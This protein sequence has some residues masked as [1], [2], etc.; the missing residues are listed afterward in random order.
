MKQRL[1]LF[2]LTPLLLS[3]TTLSNADTIG[4][5]AEI[6]KSIPEASL[7]ADPKSQAWAHSARTIL[8]VAEE[9][10]TETIASIQKITDKQNT[11]LFCLPNNE[12]IGLDIVHKTLEKNVENL[13]RNNESKTLSE[14]VITDLIAHYPCPADGFKSAQNELFSSKNYQMESRS[15]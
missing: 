9:S 5:Y 3:M 2:L 11:P 7:K 6:L 15:Q 10:I 13:K 14:V 1:C 8:A 12:E 4:R